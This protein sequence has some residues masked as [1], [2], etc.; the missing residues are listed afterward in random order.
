MR[1][2]P[3]LALIVA[4]VLFAVI[5]IM[6]LPIFYVLPLIGPALAVGSPADYVADAKPVARNA[7]NLVLG[8]L[9]LACV[10]VVV[11]TPRL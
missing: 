4:A 11:L 8:I 2:R 5:P 9:N 7:R 1:I 10:A 6:G 3:W